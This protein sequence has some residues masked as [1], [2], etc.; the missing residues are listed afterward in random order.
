M[1]IR[2]NPRP[3][4]TLIELLVVI[5]IIAIL[6][7][8]LLPAVQKVREAA[9]RMKCQNNLKQIALAAHNCHDT[10]GY[11]PPAFGKYGDGLGNHF[12]LLLEF[13]E[14]GN[15]VRLA[16]NTN[17]VYDS[18]SSLGSSQLGQAI[19]IYICPSDTHLDLVTTI[20]WSGGSYAVNFQA[21]ANGPDLVG[22]PSYPWFYS[23]TA[24]YGLNI[25]GLYW[26]YF[27]GKKRILASFPD[28]TSSTILYAEKM[29]TVIFRWDSL[30][31]GQPVFAAWTTG[32]ASKFLLSPQPFSRTD[33]R[34]QGPHTVL[35]VAL[36]DGSVRAL[37]SGISPDTWWYLCT[38]A[39]GEV[40]GDY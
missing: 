3:G 40:V 1:G 33:Y 21:V 38:P 15:K 13:V 36:A 7:G 2:K 10:Y 11:L 34:A 29:A 5:A 17:G 12:F 25:S 31:D 32:A 37:S 39:G 22:K 6:I 8:L 4:F 28:G 26:Q 14:Q 30:D 9:A 16:T 18:R 27:E 35:N 24:Y 20:G 19:P 23:H